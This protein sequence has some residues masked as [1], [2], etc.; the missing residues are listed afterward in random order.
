MNKTSP[1]SKIAF[2]CFTSNYPSQSLGKP[3]VRS[4]GVTQ[5]SYFNSPISRN[6]IFSSV[7]QGCHLMKDLYTCL[8][9]IEKIVTFTLFCSASSSRLNRIPGPGSE[10]R[11]GTETLNKQQPSGVSQLPIPF[12]QLA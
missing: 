10:Q 8:I 7:S 3:A 4:G 6:Q 1:V 9:R 12:H 11:K 5:I 2:Q